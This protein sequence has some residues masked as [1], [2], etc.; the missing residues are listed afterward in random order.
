M[1]WRRQLDAVDPRQVLQRGYSLTRNADG[2]LIRS[3]A[4]IAP[5]ES[6]VTVVADGDHTSTV[7]KSAGKKATTQARK[8]K[9]ASNTDPDDP[10]TQ[11]DLFSECR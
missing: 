5:G 9:A 11:M 10:S 6:I 8:T 2:T 7:T 1:A 3:V 4:D